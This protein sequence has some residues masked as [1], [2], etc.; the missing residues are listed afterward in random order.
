MKSWR[1][2]TTSSIMRS[3]RP[4]KN[5][6]FVRSS[7]SKLLDN[8]KKSAKISNS[9]LTQ[10]TWE[11]KRLMLKTSRWRLKCKKLLKRFTFQAKTRLLKDWALS[12]KMTVII[13]FKD[14][15]K[16]LKWPILFKKRAIWMV[17]ASRWTTIWVH[18]PSL[19]AFKCRRLP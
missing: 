12:M 14:T 13:C 19:L 16:V 10:K 15:S 8:F 4:K 18:L 1:K 11:L 3:S 7:G 6:M 2:R 17:T 9:W 5:A